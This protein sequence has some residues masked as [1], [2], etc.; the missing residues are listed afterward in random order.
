[1]IVFSSFSRKFIIKQINC[2]ILTSLPTPHPHRGQILENWNNYFGKSIWNSQNFTVSPKNHM[3]TSTL[4]GGLH[5]LIISTP[6]RYQVGIYTRGT[7][8][9]KM[10]T[11]DVITFSLWH[12]YQKLF[13]LTLAEIEKWPITQLLLLR[14]LTWE[15]FTLI[16]PLQSWIRGWRQIHEIKWNRF[17]MF[18]SWF[19]AIFYRMVSKFGYWVDGS[20]LVIKYKHFR[21]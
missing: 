13:L 4:R 12:R 8:W 6:T 21:D 1:M 3:Q 17:G 14:G 9:Q 18:Y 10:L 19:F 5:P 15:T 16:A 20:V 11:I 7:P 2:I